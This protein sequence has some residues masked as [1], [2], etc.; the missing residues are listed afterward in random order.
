MTAMACAP[1][2]V[3]SLES[4]PTA[5]NS[6]E[7]EK[8]SPF[9]VPHIVFEGPVEEPAATSAILLLKALQERG[10]HAIVLEIN[11]PGGIVS[12]GFRI[13]KAI[14]SSTVPV[15]CIVD[16]EADSMGFYILQ[17][18]H[19]RIMTK[20]SVLMAHQPS[21]NGGG[22]GGA[23]DWKS[24]S[25]SLRTL[26]DAM[27]EHM[28]HR[29]KV[30]PEEMKA[31]ISGSTMWWFNWKDGLQFGAVDMVAVNPVDVIGSLR[32]TGDLPLLITEPPKSDS[33]CSHQ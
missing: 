26:S 15:V 17:S 23:D 30:T 16:G 19:V 20:R 25:E 3:A 28:S 33:V 32:Q 27:I 10:A 1:V 14:E 18:C 22:G 9:Y 29:M 7:A 31:R 13:S 24:I 12:D 8:E 11:T 4:P 21:I 2:R 6:V 5:K